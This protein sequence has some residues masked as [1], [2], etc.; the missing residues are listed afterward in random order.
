MVSS[1]RISHQFYTC[2]IVSLA[3]TIAQV[4]INKANKK[5]YTIIFNELQELM[6]RLTGKL[7]WFK[8]LSPDGNLLCM[9]VDMEAAKVLGAAW[10]FMKMNDIRYSKID[11]SSPEELLLYFVWVCLTHS[12]QYAY[13]LTQVIMTLILNHANGVLYFKFLVTA[14]D[15]WWIFNFPY[16]KLHVELDN[17]TLFINSL[18]IKKIQGKIY[19]VMWD[20]NIGLTFP[21]LVEP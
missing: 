14:S 5:Y 10:S 2:W 1:L 9:N 16:M 13:F 11:V 21:R 18:G 19:P 6:L 7:L 8:I 20:P 15:Y 3:I 17:F 12:K 4:Y